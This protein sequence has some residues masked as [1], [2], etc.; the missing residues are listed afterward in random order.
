[1]DYITAQAPP[2]PIKVNGKEYKVP[3]FLSAE[4]KAYVAAEREKAY[5]E[6]LAEIPDQDSR[7]RFRLY[8]QK[9]PVD[10]LYVAKELTTP[11]GAEHVIRTCLAKAGVPAEEIEG[12]VV[13]VDPELQRSLA[14]ELRSGNGMIATQLAASGD[15]GDA[16]NPTTGQSPTSGGSP[17]TTAQTS[18][19]GSEPTPAANPTA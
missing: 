10:V 17:T 3:R 6:A 19:T 7:A 16:G 12:F 4:F 5:T 15:P 18:P 14:D 11:E 9:P 1:M 2:H 8:H 13:N